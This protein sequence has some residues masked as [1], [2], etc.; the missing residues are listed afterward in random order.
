MLTET[1]GRK[2]KKE[3]NLKIAFGLPMEHFSLS[4]KLAARVVSKI[5]LI[6]FVL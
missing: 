6:G 2:K 1:R 3:K 5:V 4:N